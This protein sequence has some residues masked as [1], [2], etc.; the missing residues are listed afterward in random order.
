ME[1]AFSVF[2]ASVAEP[3][4]KRSALENGGLF[5]LL[6]ASAVF[7]TIIWFA[8]RRW[9]AISAMLGV[10]PCDSMAWVAHC[11]KAAQA[12]ALA[13]ATHW[14]ALSTLPYGWLALSIAL[15]VA[16]QHLNVLVYAR[17]GHEGVYYGT[18]F[19]K[20]VPWVT[21]YPYSVIR[22]P[23]YV[24]AILTVLGLAVIGPLDLV[25]FLIAQYV[26]LIALESTPGGS[27]ERT[28]AAARS[29]RSKT[30]SSKRKRVLPQS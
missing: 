16:G 4:S 22:D 25:I 18:R 15:V 26:Y 29:P 11:L 28:P 9:S 7:Y 6:S 24:G 13:A 8:P 23:Q 21:A 3:F 30:P 14:G 12:V 10:D 27:A 5:S 19:G 1:A 2:A 20:R 17:L